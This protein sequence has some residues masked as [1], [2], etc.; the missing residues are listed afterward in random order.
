MTHEGVYSPEDFMTTDFAEYVRNTFGMP[1]VTV[2]TFE[3]GPGD[4]APQTPYMVS[5]ISP[6]VAEVV[7]NL[8]YPVSPDYFRLNN[9]A[10]FQSVVGQVLRKQLSTQPIVIGVGSNV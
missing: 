6:A 1:K 9:K 10:H 8:G 4:V 7:N 2:R 3:E 5:D